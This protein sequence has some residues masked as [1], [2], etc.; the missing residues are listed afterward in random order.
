MLKFITYSLSHHTKLQYSSINKLKWQKQTSDILEIQAGILPPS[1]HWQVKVY[2]DPRI[3]HQP[4]E[5]LLR[6]RSI[7][8]HVAGSKAPQPRCDWATPR[9]PNSAKKSP[10]ITSWS[11]VLGQK[12]G[13]AEVSHVNS[14][15]P[16]KARFGIYDRSTFAYILCKSCVRLCLD[17]N[18]FCKT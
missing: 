7:F 13:I 18:P 12:L 16:N 11:W 17:L 6:D 3:T 2:V 15:R 8:S 14:F 5:F 4:Y 9:A 10:E 1:V